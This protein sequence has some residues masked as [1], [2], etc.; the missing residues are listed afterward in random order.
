MKT[1]LVIPCFMAK[2]MLKKV[3]KG[4]PKFVNFI[5]LVDDNC[6]EKTVS[7]TLK[8]ISDKRIYAIYNKQNIGVGGSVLIGYKKA[9][10]LGSDLVIKIDS[11]GQMDLSKL[12]KIFKIFK[13]DR[14]LAYVKGN[15]FYSIKSIIKMPFIRLF[16]NL[17]LTLMNK[18]SSGYWKINDPTNGYTAINTNYLKRLKLN[19][20]KKK[21]FFESDMLF[22]LNCLGAK[23]YDI[24]IEA[25]YNVNNSSTLV[26]YKVIPYFIK[27][28]IINF[29][30]RIFRNVILLILYLISI[31][32]FLSIFLNDLNFIFFL[33]IFLL[34]ILY[35]ITKQPK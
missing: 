5:I 27:N 6:P 12:P 30:K 13:A 16:G 28:H 15:R 18:F 24:D 20:I 2:K 9:I 17:I 4:I 14:G 34:T 25:K 22:H 31:T 1:A 33:I 23:V 8:T 26:I 29:A 32:L 3:L 35:D 19:K 21:F 7:Y 10:Q 11:D